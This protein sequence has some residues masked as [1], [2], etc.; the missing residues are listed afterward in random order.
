MKK[1]IEG[2][3]EMLV[4]KFKIAVALKSMKEV[5]MVTDDSS[6]IE[7]CVAENSSQW[8]LLSGQSEVCKQP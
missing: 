2:Q 4:R 6:L 8:T 5:N 3:A 7:V 1:F